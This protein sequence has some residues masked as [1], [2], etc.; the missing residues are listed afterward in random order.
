MAV[1][2]TGTQ[3]TIEDIEAVACFGETVKLHP[4]ALGRI[5]TIKAR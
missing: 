4:D 3:L 5:V 1:T 2:V